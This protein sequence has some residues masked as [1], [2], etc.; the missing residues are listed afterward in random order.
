MNERRG[1]Y[2]LMTEK[3]CDK[4]SKSFKNFKKGGEKSEE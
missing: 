1:V 4:V 3:R 2:G